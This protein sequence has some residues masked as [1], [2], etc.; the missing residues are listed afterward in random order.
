[1]YLNFSARKTHEAYPIS[2][3]AK[4]KLDDE[5]IEAIKRHP[6]EVYG[7]DETMMDKVVQSLKAFRG[8]KDIDEEQNNNNS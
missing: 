1:M 6:G 3:E 4:N 7:K 2:K 5:L 8:T